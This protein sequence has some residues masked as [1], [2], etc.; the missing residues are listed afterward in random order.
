VNQS[1]RDYLKP[2]VVSVV[3]AGDF[4]KVAKESG[5]KAATAK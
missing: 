5:A 2:E 3:T 4:A 1:L